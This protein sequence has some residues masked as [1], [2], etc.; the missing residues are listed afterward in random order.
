MVRFGFPGIDS[1]VRLYRKEGSFFAGSVHEK[2]VTQGLA[3]RVALPLYHRQPTNNY[4]RASFQN[5]WLNYIEIEARE[6]GE[7]PPPRRLLYRS[8]A[9]GAFLLR[10]LRDL[11]LLGGILDGFRGIKIALLLAYYRYRLL[12]R[13]GAKP[14]E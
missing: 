9:P 2:A 13:L 7:I 4:T 6:R 5:K 3:K 11:F 8:A 1:L 12:M 14:N 10:L